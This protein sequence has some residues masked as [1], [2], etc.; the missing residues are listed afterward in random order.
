MDDYAINR[1]PIDEV[2]DEQGYTVIGAANGAAGLKVLQS[3]ARIELLITDVGL[4]LVTGAPFCIVNVRGGRE[5]LGLMRQHVT[6]I[7]AACAIG[8]GA[9]G[10]GVAVGAREI[11]FRPGKV[12]AAEY[13]FLVG[14]AGS[15][16]LVVQTVLMPRL[17]ASGPSRLVLGG[18]PHN[19]LA[20]AFDFNAK[21]YLP[22][23]RRMVEA[24][25]ARHGFYPRGG[26]RSRCADEGARLP[27][28]SR[29]LG[30]FRAA[31]YRGRTDPKSSDPYPVIDVASMLLSN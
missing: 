15:T 21:A 13:R 11:T 2:L 28:C 14:T 23:S 31:A 6:A 29:P 22:L 19:M 5:K 26:G 16:G 8:V 7:K 27:W 24:R 17:L 20:P 12:G 9:A 3:G 4:S 18:G 30:T 25:L 10:E 1:Y